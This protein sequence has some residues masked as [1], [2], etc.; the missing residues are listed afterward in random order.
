MNMNE[1]YV[2]LVRSVVIGILLLPVIAMAIGALQ[3]MEEGK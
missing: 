2:W 1:I 3:D